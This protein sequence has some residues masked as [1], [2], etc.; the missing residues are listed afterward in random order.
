MIVPIAVM[1]IV[2]LVEAPGLLR[3]P[4]PWERWAFLVIWAA[5]TA[6]VIMAR[7]HG[8]A[9]LPGLTDRL[10][11]RLVSGCCAPSRTSSGEGPDPVGDRLLYFSPPPGAPRPPGGARGECAP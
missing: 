1:A 9:G 4:G 8:T 3:T 7:L 11:R 6:W 5:I 10:F 2:L